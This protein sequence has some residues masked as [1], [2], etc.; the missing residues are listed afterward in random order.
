MMEIAFLVNGFDPED[1][2]ENFDGKK[3]T[4]SLNLCG[5]ILL[6]LLVANFLI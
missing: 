4:V 1:D 5:V 3:N 2:L 6:K